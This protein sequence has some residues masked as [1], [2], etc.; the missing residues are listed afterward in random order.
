MKDV[1][2]KVLSRDPTEDLNKHGYIEIDGTVSFTSAPISSHGEFG[3]Y[4]IGVD[5]ES[6]CRNF[7]CIDV[8]YEF[9]WMEE[10]PDV[11]LRVTG[12]TMDDWMEWAKENYDMMY[13][14]KGKNPTH[15][16]LASLIWDEIYTLYAWEEEVVVEGHPIL[17]YQSDI[18]YLGDVEGIKKH[19]SRGV[20]RPGWFGEPQR[21]AL[22]AR[23]MR[24][25]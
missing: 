22:A 19:I 5:R 6:V 12:Q 7:K 16:E 8:M 2:Y 13:G 10:H 25:K 3:E 18:M 21:H 4:V 20:G 11:L 14:Y 24:T 15:S 9:S 17:I 23:G 1:I